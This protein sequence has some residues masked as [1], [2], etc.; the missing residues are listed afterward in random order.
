MLLKKSEINRK[1]V[2]IMQ[3]IEINNV[4]KTGLPLYE[5]MKLWNLEGKYTNI[6]I[7]VINLLPGNRVPTGD[8][9]SCHDADEYSV[10]VSGEVYTESGDYKDVCKAGEATLIPKGEKHWCENRTDK[11]CTI[12][13]VMA[14]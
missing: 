10:F 14:K 6:D 13:C 11:P 7:S 2:Y 3:K 4:P 8:G 9:F 5:M 12:V 1:K